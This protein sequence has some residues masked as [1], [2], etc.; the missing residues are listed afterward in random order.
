M[1]E[2][3]EIL[4][5]FLFK[6]DSKPSAP[7]LP[8]TV[9]IECISASSIEPELLLWLWENRIP[10]GKLTVFCGP[11]DTGKSTVAIDIAARGTCAESW[12]DSLNPNWPFDVL[13]LVSED[14]LADTTVPRLMAAGADLS[15]IHFA[16][17]TVISDNAKRQERQIALDTDLDAIEAVLREKPE[18]KLV[19]LDPLSAYLGKLKKNSD[20]EIRWV[21]TLMKELAE[22]TGVAVISID[23]F[24]KN[25]Q[26]AA[27]HRL[28][29]AGAL[30]AVPRAVWAFVK[31]ADDEEKLTRLMLNAKLNVVSE[32]KKA[33]LKYRFKDVQ[34]TIKDQEATIPAVDWL[35]Q[36]DS[37]LEEVLHKQADPDKGQ[38][39]NC[40]AWLQSRLA[41]GP[42]LS[43]EIY[44]EAESAGYSEKTVRRA[45]TRLG[46]R[47]KKSGDGWR[48]ELPQGGQQAKEQSQQ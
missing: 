25:I 17:R 43:R 10:L 16:K 6:D 37:D 47:S 45:V 27:I 44:T 36:S 34:L 30:A 14:D 38:L 46:I 13:M 28:S 32:A 8:I 12:P 31:D 35:G 39:E 26:Q 11:P 24:N 22:R 15:R 33:G 3:S 18:I 42:V 48:M 5:E 41:D 20:E 9:S 21:L 1:S 7:K 2:L 4:P 23:H 19:I 29:G 40:A